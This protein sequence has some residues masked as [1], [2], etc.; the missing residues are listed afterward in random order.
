[1]KRYL[2]LIAWMRNIGLF[3]LLIIGVILSVILFSLRIAPVSEKYNSIKSE[4]FRQI[5]KQFTLGTLTGVE[6]I[7]T[8]RLGIVREKNSEKLRSDNLEG[9]LAEYLNSIELDERANKEQEARKVQIVKGLIRDLASEK[10]YS[11]LPKEAQSIAVDLKESIEYGDTQGALA[12]LEKL[13]TSLGSKISMF[14]DRA[15]KNWRWTITS[16]LLGATGILV[17]ILLSVVSRRWA[18]FRKTMKIHR[19]KGLKST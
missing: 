11:V 12:R 5:D 1:M 8:I 13:A 4:F 7:E 18:S 17:T 19:D 2:A 10:P 14:E 6:D 9:L 15:E 3:V 16:V